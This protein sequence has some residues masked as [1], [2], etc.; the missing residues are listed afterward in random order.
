MMENKTLARWMK[1][2]LVC[3][4][5][6]G[7]LACVWAIPVLGR[8]A[9]EQIDGGERYYTAWLIFLE[10]CAIPCFAA[11]G[12]AWGVAGRIGENR[13]FCLENAAA[14]KRIAWYAGGDSAFFLAGNVLLLLLN[15]N[16]PG[17]LLCSLAVVLLGGALTVAAGVLSVLIGRAAGLQEQSD[18]TI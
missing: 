3:L 17:V 7:A 18:W 16:H 11:L 12:A 5:L 9:E 13:S 8:D 6:L 15:R 10:L 4:A 1:V 2:V 14:M